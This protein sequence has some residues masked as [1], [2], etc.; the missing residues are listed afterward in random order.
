[1]SAPPDGLAAPHADGLSLKLRV[2]PNAKRDAVIGVRIW[3]EET[4]LL[5]RVRA[6]AEDGKAN[7]AVTRVL[8]RW[9]D[10]ASQDVRLVSGERSR[11]KTVVATGEP[12]ALSRRLDERLDRL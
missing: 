7:A 5:L 3:G 2:T 12:D 4:R 8:A 1:M 6:P 10:L 9:L 11:L